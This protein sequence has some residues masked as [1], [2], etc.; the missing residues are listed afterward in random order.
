ML[1][2]IDPR[3]VAVEPHNLLLPI[4]TLRASCG[5]S[6][7]PSPAQDYDGGEIDLNQQLVPRPTS[8]FVFEASGD[9]MQRPDGSGIFAGD[10]LIV[11]RSIQPR[12]GDCVVAIVDGELLVKELR[13]QGS[14]PA[15]LSSNSRYAPIPL[16]DS[17]TQIWGVVTNVLRTMKR[18]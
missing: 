13:T 18:C 1:R 9:S 6:G 2:A 11:D 3:P 10:T 4:S 16:S 17:D 12:N 14:F 8:T 7:F 15:L 5:L